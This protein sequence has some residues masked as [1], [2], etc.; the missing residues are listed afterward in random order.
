VLPGSNTLDVIRRVREQMK[1]IQAQLPVGM[2]AG[3]PYDSTR[4]IE[5]SIHEVLKTLT[6]TLL[7]VI[8]VIFLFLGSIRGLLIPARRDPDLADRR[9]VPHERA[10]FTINLLTLLAIV[11]SVG[12]GRRRR[13][14]HG[15]ERRAPR[16]RGEPPIQAAIR[17]RASC[18]ARSSP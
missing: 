18:W 16:A 17:R 11:L 12:L 2:T 8:L 5:D 10:G 13:D 9:R 3:I 1:D 7:I 6:E 14:R 4:Y 15:R